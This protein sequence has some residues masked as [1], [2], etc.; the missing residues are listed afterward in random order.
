MSMASARAI[1]EEGCGCGT[2]VSANGDGKAIEGVG[3]AI[4]GPKSSLRAGLPRRV[5][6]A[7]ICG[8]TAGRE[9]VAD[10]HIRA[11]PPFCTD[12]G[13]SPLVICRFAGLVWAAASLG[14]RGRLFGRCFNGAL[15]ELLLARMT[16]SSG[17]SRSGPGRCMA[18][19]VGCGGRRREGRREGAGWRGWCRE[20]GWDGVGDAR[21]SASPDGSCCLL[22]INQGASHQAP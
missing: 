8:R 22:T 9:S 1:D 2:N 18:V 5:V 7:S 14:E 11:A 13:H 16:W 15:W 17:M 19:R 3:C 21:R 12:E 4:A 6:G 20:G 10:D